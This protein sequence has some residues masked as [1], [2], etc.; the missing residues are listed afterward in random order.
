MNTLT[1]L[2]E[3]MVLLLHCFLFYIISTLVIEGKA[4]QT[5]GSCRRGDPGRGAGGR[6][7]PRGCC[8]CCCQPVTGTRQ[9]HTSKIKV[10]IFLLLAI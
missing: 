1:S 6:W 5:A 9:G 10:T 2:N 4:A 8:C 7:A 3:V